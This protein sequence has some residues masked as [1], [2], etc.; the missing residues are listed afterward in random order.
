MKNNKLYRTMETYEWK[1]ERKV[2][3]TWAVPKYTKNK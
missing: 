3:K 1:L 2:K